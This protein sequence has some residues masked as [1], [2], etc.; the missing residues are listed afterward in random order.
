MKLGGDLTQERLRE[1]IAY[2]PITGRF[3]WTKARRSV[4]V[5]KE[6]GTINSRG[7]RNLCIDGTLYLAHRVA[8]FYM[9]GVWPEQ[10][11]HINGNKADNRWENLRE[12]TAAENGQN[13]ALN[14]RNKVGLPGVFFN[15]T[16]NRWQASIQIAGKPKY[17][18]RYKTAEEAGAAYIQ[19]KAR[20]HTF[21]PTVRL[22][23]G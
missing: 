9:H 11:D 16:R 10:I 13:L 5:G 12:C 8:W 20:L 18:G 6:A 17:L 19:A 23:H 2:E 21:Q 14:P 15:N 7:Y 22:S 3:I 1:L 4:T